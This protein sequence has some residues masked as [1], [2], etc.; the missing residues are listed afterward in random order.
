M[1][2]SL[3]L[4]HDRNCPSFDFSMIKIYDYKSVG[5]LAIISEHDGIEE[6]GVQL[7]GKINEKTIRIE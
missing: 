1:T 2:Q 5:F 3:F 7:R 6:I 4:I